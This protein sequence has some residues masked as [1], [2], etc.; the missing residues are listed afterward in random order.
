MHYIYISKINI[1]Q[2]N[3]MIE[4]KIYIYIYI[5]LTLEY[6]YTYIK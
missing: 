4:R 2:L 1:V 3:T 5:Y 6:I